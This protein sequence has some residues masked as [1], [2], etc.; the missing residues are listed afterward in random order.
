[1][2]DR[3]RFCIVYTAINVQRYSVLNKRKNMFRVSFKVRVTSARFGAKCES[4]D[5]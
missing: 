2:S 3:T 4:Y 5:S 1:V